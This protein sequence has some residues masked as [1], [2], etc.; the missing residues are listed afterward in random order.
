M[1]RILVT[2]ASGTVGSALVQALVSDGWIVRG[3]VHSQ[4]VVGADETAAGDVATGAGLDGALDGVATVIHLAAATHARSPHVYEEVNVRGTA[5]LVAAAERAGVRRFVHVSTRAA[6]AYGGAYSRSKADAEAIVVGSGIPYVI[7]RL[8]E[9]YGTGGSEG[10]D[11][12]IAQARSGKPILVVGAGLQEVCPISAEDAFAALVAATHAERAHGVT[13]TLAG[14]CMTV[15][16]FAERCVRA[17]GSRSRIVGVPEPLVAVAARA[18]RVL[19]LPIYPDQL[20]RL[21]ALKP[22]LSGRARLDLGFAPRTL[23]ETLER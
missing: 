10:V 14:E 12:V 1:P 8:P 19:P 22:A 9:V 15:R 18:S 21:R 7:V 17:L 23:E 16:A 20:A 5:N 3:L 4:P 2:G 6:S 11:G 13:Y